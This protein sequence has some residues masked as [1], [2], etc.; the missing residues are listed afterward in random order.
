[1]KLGGLSAASA[2]GLSFDSFKDIDGILE[3]MPLE[4]NERVLDLP[5]SMLAGAFEEASAW[6]K[7][8][9]GGVRWE[10]EKVREGPFPGVRQ[11]RCVVCTK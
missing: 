8:D 10:L 4:G 2:W 7:D 6:I 5:D 9:H 3:A 11:S 1:M